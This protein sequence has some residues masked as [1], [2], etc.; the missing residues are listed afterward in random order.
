MGSEL[1]RMIRDGAPPDWTAHMRLVAMV[2]ADDARD[3]GQGPPEDGGWPW[4]AIRVSGHERDGAWHDGIAERTGMSERA[5]SRA[6]TT[7]ARAGYEMRE[8]I[9]TDKHGRPVFTLTG[10]R[11]LR[12]RVPPLYPRDGPPK[13]ATLSPPYPATLSPPDS[14]TRQHARFG[15]PSL[16]DSATLSPPNPATRQHA[17]FGDHRAGSPDSARHGPP[18]SATPS[19]HIPPNTQIQV[20]N[21]YLEG[22]HAAAATDDD[23]DSST[24]PASLDGR[25]EG[26]TVAA[27]RPA[28]QGRA[29]RLTLGWDEPTGPGYGHCP[30]CGRWVSVRGRGRLV[31]HVGRVDGQECPGSRGRPAE[32]V[33]C[34]ACGRTGM[35]IHGDGRCASCRRNYWRTP[36]DV[37]PSYYPADP[38]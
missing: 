9:G 36:A 15:D 1:Y 10:R 7:L 19:P 13:T 2:I 34:T 11:A 28:S 4:S 22:D 30:D 37:P 18:D 32:P 14:A 23:D 20:V 35:A 8:P 25:A 29:A 21:S 27:A 38:P 31:R 33:H 5:I 17:E 26:A 24:Q 16:P 3:P 12:F 6:L